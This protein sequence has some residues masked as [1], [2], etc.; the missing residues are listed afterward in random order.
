MITKTIHS[1]KG[2]IHI[3]LDEQRCLLAAKP[4][5][6]ISPELVKEDLKEAY[7]F[8][9]KLKRPWTYSVDTTFVTFAHP[10]NIFQL[11]KIKSLPY[12]D[13]YYLIS[14]SIIVRALSFVFLPF[15]KVDRV[16]K[17]S[18]ELD[19]YLDIR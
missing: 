3:I 17:S 16:F 12:I 10:F 15:I 5:G 13:K 8:G 7:S 6:F 2:S 19:L 9:Q 4:R 1:P 11:R 18:K 14:P